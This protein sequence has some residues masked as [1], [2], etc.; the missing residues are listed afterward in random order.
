MSLQTVSLRFAR[1]LIYIPN[2]NYP[3]QIPLFFISRVRPSHFW[4]QMLSG[5]DLD[6][7]EFLDQ[8][9]EPCRSRKNIYVLPLR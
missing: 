6:L 1:V 5:T 4:D 9:G 2:I 3:D 7:P 8:E